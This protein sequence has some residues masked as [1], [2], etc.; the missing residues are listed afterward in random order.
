M[1]IPIPGLRAETC[2]RDMGN[3]ARAIGRKLLPMKDAQL[4]GETNAT[5]NAEIAM[6]ENQIRSFGEMVI[7]C[8]ETQ[9]RYYV[10]D[11]MLRSSI[12]MSVRVAIE[13]GY[14]RVR[15]ILSAH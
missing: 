10:R 7:L 1:L 2:A 4:H 9:E 13:K 3:E 6:L 12:A 15:R 5:D 14:E 11:Y 8:T